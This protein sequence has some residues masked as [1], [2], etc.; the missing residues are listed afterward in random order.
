VRRSLIPILAL[1]AL[2]HGAVTAA[3]AV[4]AGKD[5]PAHASIVGGGPAAAG[6]WRFAVALE[7]KRRL[8]CTGSLIAPATVLTAA[9]CLK[10]VKRRHLTVLAG[11]PWIST[12]RRGERIGVAR[13]RLH[14]RFNGRKDLRDFG[15]VTLERESAAPPIALPTRAEAAAA[16]A[17]GRT[18]RTAGWGAV[19][20]FGFRVAQRLK[21]T[22]ER[23]YRARRCNRAYTRKGFFPKSMICA[24]GARVRRLDGGRSFHST[25]CTG[26][27]G[28]PVIAEAPA[29]P[30]LVGVV[31]SG[32]F[33]CGL[34]PSIYA[35][36]SEALPFIEAAAQSP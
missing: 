34:A 4:A 12:P 7:E 14:P 35:R 5:Q 18:L 24:L 36:V 13:V 25:A 2:G 28:G 21:A 29:G 27:S 20:P 3:G 10:A 33:P 9:H 32:V 17:P 31:V 16:T 11:S 8:V 23:V 19:S 6:G 30:R 22:R 15:V 26:D 1:A